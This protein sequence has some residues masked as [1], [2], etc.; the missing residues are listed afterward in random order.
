MR[1]LSCIAL[2]V[3]ILLLMVTSSSGK[4]SKLVKS[5]KS[6]TRVAAN[7][8]HRVLALGL[9]D[10]TVVRAEFEDALAAQL[11]QLG[12]EAIP[13]NTILL[14]PEGTQFDL[15]YLRTQIREHKI[16]TVAV[17]RLIHVENTTTYVPGAHYFPP[18]PYYG[19]FYG[20]Y[21]TVYPMV[22]SPGY[23]K[24]EKRVRIETNLYV[25][26]S[27]EGNLVWTCVTDTFN[28]SNMR[29]AIDRLVKLVVKQMQSDSVI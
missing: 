28:P 9:S 15:D 5:W 26:T 14:R 21:G 25:I 29:K 17:A 11:A 12:I 7:K 23:L 2:V 10:K 19:T 20:Y 27:E 18:Y 4:P 22:Y 6:P 8:L 13:G 24:E 3:L 1:Y 16:D